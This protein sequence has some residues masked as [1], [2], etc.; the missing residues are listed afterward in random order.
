MAGNLYHHYLLANL[1]SG[2]DSK[3][4]DGEKKYVAP[5]GGLFNYVAAPHYFFE[6]LGW[7]GIAVVAQ[8]MNAYL[9]FAGMTSYLSGRAC[10]QNEWN[11]SKFSEADWPA[12]RKNV[13]PFIF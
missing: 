1:R 2:N 8:Q 9:V 11:R 5:K 10:S 7:L 12:S 4:T 13:I 6:L 3:K